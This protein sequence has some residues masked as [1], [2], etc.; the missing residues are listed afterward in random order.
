M[1]ENRMCGETS[2]ILVA[3]AAEFFFDGRHLEVPT[4]VIVLHIP[5]SVDDYARGL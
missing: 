1:F 5:G 4:D 3:V 2:A